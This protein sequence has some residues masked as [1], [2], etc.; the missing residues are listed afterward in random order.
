MLPKNTTFV[1]KVEYLQRFSKAVR[2]WTLLP[3]VVADD[4][5]CRDSSHYNAANAQ[6]VRLRNNAASLADMLVNNTKYC[7]Q[8][9]L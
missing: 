2:P 3:A 8:H 1:H 6:E 5:F 9:E 4:H 7:S